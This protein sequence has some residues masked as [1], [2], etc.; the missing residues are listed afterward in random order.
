M[1]EFDYIVVG[2][3]SSGC[4][5]ASRLS[6]G[7]N[8]SVCLVEAGPKNNTWSVNIPMAL[9]RL[10]TDPK[11]N[12]GFNTRPEPHLNLRRISQHRGRG[13]GGSSAI[14]SMVYIRG[15][16]HDYDTWS[17]L[18][19]SG[20]SYD[21][22]LP[23]F[24]K[25]EHYFDGENQ[26][27]GSGGPLH[28]NKL[29][30]T[31]NATTT[32][33]EAAQEQGYPITDDFNG[34]QQEGFNAYHVTQ[35]NGQRCSSA[36]AF[37]YPALSRSNLHVKTDTQV[38]KILFNESKRAAGIIVQSNG[39]T[40]VLKARKEIILSAGAINTP[41]LLM[42][43]GVG[44]QEELAKHNIPLVHSLSGVGKNLQDHLDTS[45]SYWAKAGFGMALSLSF[46]PVFAK[47]LVDYFLR[48]KKGVLSSNIVEAGGFVSTSPDLPAPDLQFHFISG[49]TSGG[50]ALR[51][52]H[53]Y[54][55]G[56]C[57][58]RPESRGS[59]TL[60]SA[61]IKDSPNIDCN[62]LASEKDR[63]TQLAG[64]KIVN[65]IVTSK[66]FDKYRLKQRIPESPIETEEQL[67]EHIKASSSTVYHPVG[68]CKMGVRSDPM[69]VVSSENLAVFGL[70]GLRIA[71]AS[72]MPTL[73]S[74]NTNAPCIMIGEKLSDMVKST[75]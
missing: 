73:I 14:N 3:G 49:T 32:F 22:V 10:M 7:E 34:Y 52:G 51:W 62:F 64:L 8:Y 59:I 23:Y 26:Y 20:W 37:I 19:N 42:V 56:A 36:K 4:V 25:S 5:V 29:R 66:A 16:R 74:G 63:Q 60:K 24:K 35:I 68:T 17:N 70:K 61:D 40:E 75:W 30:W 53:S 58:L 45:V 65:D 47:G 6:E 67:V 72:I 39:K 46:A 31:S 1:K 2:G 48:G 27:H 43:S 13:L 55:L 38:L 44:P 28:V 33:L 11:R 21:E 15:H 12:W 71:D 54:L 18:G 69:A 9:H 57:V 50:H 41:H